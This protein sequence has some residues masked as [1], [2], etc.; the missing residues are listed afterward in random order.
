MKINKT[1]LFLFLYYRKI[2]HVNWIPIIYSKICL[3][4]ERCTSTMH[5][6]LTITSR[7]EE[8]GEEVSIGA[9][10]D[11][12]EELHILRCGSRLGGD[13]QEE[14]GN[15]WGVFGETTVLVWPQLGL[16]GAED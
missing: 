12:G 8:F 3:I 1:L 2:K 13:E 10:P 14:R 15:A 11:L 5:W 7:G 4:Q 16:H 9:A 6:G